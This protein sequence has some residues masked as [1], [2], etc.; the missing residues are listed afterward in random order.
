VEGGDTREVA[1]RTFLSENTVQDHLKAIFAE[2]SARSRRTL[3]ARAL[4]S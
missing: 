4:G 2:T 1:Q 3:L